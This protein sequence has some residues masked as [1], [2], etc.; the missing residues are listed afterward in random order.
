MQGRTGGGALG[1]R[2]RAA[3]PGEAATHTWGYLQHCSAPGIPDKALECVGVVGEPI[4]A[5]SVVRLDVC[6][7][8]AQ[9]LAVAGQASSGGVARHGPIDQA[10]SCIEC[11][12]AASPQ[13]GRHCGAAAGRR[14]RSGWVGPPGLATGL[15]HS[16]TTR[17]QAAELSKQQPEGGSCGMP[18]S[19]PLGARSE[20]P[21]ACRRAAHLLARRRRRGSLRPRACSTCRCHH[22]SSPA[23]SRRPAA[24]S[25]LARWSRCR[26]RRCCLLGTPRWRPAAGAHAASSLPGA[27]ADHRPQAMAPGVT[28]T[29]PGAVPANHA[30][31]PREARPGSVNV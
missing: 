11:L 31:C 18:A 29:M 28:A 12:P 4:P 22:R 19:P 9:V 27:G 21:H 7:D 26:P 3:S 13:H 17:A 16:A 25:W 23:A 1:S 20:P 30:A 2:P 10:T 15:Q 5:G 8:A 24:A 6:G 14:V